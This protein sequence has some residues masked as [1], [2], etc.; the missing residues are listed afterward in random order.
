MKASA[1]ASAEPRKDARKYSRHVRSSSTA[2]KAK[3][4]TGPLSGPP[5]DAKCL[6]TLDT[7]FAVELTAAPPRMAAVHARA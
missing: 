6:Q 1:P 4:L 2:L 3:R 5:Y 7:S